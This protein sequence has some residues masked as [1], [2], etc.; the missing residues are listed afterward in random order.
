MRVILIQA[1]SLLARRIL[2]K[3]RPTIVAVT[4]SVGKTSTKEAIVAVLAVKFRVRASPKNYNNEI[5]VPLAI[6]G[7]PSGGRSAFGWLSVFLAGAR[8]LVARDMAYTDILVLEFGADHPG[9]I[10]ALVNLAPPRFG[11]VTAI[12]EAHYEFFGDL[13]KLIAEK[14]KIIESLPQNGCAILNI[15]DEWVSP[16][17]THTSAKALTFG[18][19]PDAA[20]R[21]LELQPSFIL[22]N[23][24]QT[25]CGMSFKISMDGAVVPVLLKNVVGI[26]HAYAALAS[27]AMG[28]AFGLNLIEI[29][30]G[31]RSYLPPS[32]RM[33]ILRGIKNTVLIDDTY[34]SSPK[35]AILALETVQKIPVGESGERFAVLGDMLELGNLSAE[36]HEKLGRRV[37]ELGYDHLVTVGHEAKKIAHAARG[38]GM[39]EHRIVSFDRAEDAGK[40]MQS[41]LES[42][43]VV[44]L[45]GS[46]G[47]RMERAVKE[48]MAEPLRAKELLCR[49]DE[50]WAS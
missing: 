25:P 19:D 8:L 45:K 18:F 30:E 35:A 15:D 3:Y 42:G 36:A 17:Q 2:A 33:H 9:D 12:G 37:H 29:A 11:V 20:V 21:G 27:A 47:V 22:E 14:R 34:N 24:M 32:G 48:I 41:H 46:Q 31:L 13:K 1:L 6:I 39:E 40:Y 49:Q 10:A 4:G 28:K 7:A 38:I 5:G 26:Q 50:G 16:M 23:E 44:L 43:D